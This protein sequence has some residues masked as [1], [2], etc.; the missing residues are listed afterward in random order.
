[1]IR[2]IISGTPWGGCCNLLLL[3]YHLRANQERRGKEGGGGGSGR[4][5][6]EVSWVELARSGPML[7]AEKYTLCPFHPGRIIAESFY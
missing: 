1:M 5:R 6:R 4:G 7:L 2:C 3:L